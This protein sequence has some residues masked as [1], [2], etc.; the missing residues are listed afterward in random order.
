MSYLDRIFENSGEVITIPNPLVF[1]GA[2]KF[3]S[4]TGMAHALTAQVEA[5]TV[6]ADAIAYLGADAATNSGIEFAGTANLTNIFKFNA[7]AGAVVSNALVPSAAP[8]ATTVGADAAL[9]CDIGGTPY[10]IALYNTLHA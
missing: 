1:T 4:G 10:Y 3:S 6:G 9:V 2:V 5:G 8:D 7:V